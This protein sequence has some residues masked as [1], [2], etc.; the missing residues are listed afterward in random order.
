MS[1]D[2]DTRSSTKET[3]I[4]TPIAA[5]EEKAASTTT[6]ETPAFPPPKYVVTI[7]SPRFIH[8]HENDASLDEWK[9]F[10]EFENNNRED[11]TTILNLH[12]LLVSLLNRLLRARLFPR[13]AVHS[14]MTPAAG[15]DDHEFWVVFSILTPAT[16]LP[17]LLSKCEHFGVGN[18][19]GLVYAVPLETC[20]LP[21]I[22]HTVEEEEEEGLLTVPSH[23]DATPLVKPTS[24]DS[25]SASLPQSQTASPPTTTTVSLTDATAAA[26]LVMA[27]SST[28]TSHKKTKTPDPATLRQVMSETLPEQDHL[29]A[30]HRAADD[31]ADNKTL[32]RT[33]SDP[34]IS[35]SSSSN[36][37]KAKDN[38]DTNATTDAKPKEPHLLE[39]IPEVK[40]V[41][42]KEEKDTT[43]TAG[44]SEHNNTKSKSDLAS[45]S[46]TKSALIEKVLDARRE[47]LATAS[48]IR[49]EQV[50]E[51]V[52]AAASLTWD[53]LLFVVCAAAIASVGL[54]TNSSVTVLASMLVS[55]IMGPILA[56]TFGTM[57]QRPTMIRTALRNEAISLLLCILVGAL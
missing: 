49:V 39:I 47:W 52:T 20:V 18:L 19:V 6:D 17:I 34:N 36:N 46:N 5:A 14:Y 11:T 56:V 45:S 42:P 43:T 30:A 23:F 33:S 15:S 12:V 53:Y 51:E 22:N 50:A 31:G 37:N 2:G 57:I 13:R 3:T 24:V 7:V 27:P 32:R 8:L 38:K 4:T 1:E 35:Q 29:A 44:T 41:P 9:E 40:K 21:L 10:E 28:S 48:R 55:P 54:A 26:V 16:V 25:K